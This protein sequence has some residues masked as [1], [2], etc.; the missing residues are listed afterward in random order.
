MFSFLKTANVSPWRRIKTIKIRG[1][2]SQ[3][4]VISLSNLPKDKIY[5]EGEDVSNIL[6]VKK[7]EKIIDDSESVGGETFPTHIITKTDEDNLRTHNDVLTELFNQKLYITLKMDGSSMSVIKDRDNFTV[8]SRRMKLDETTDMYNYV[9]KEGIREKLLS[10][11]ENIAIQGEF[12]GPKING[13]RLGLTSYHYYIFN[14]KRLDIDQY[15][16]YE[17]ILNLCTQLKLEMVPLVDKYFCNELDNIDTFQKIANTVKYTTSDNKIV[18]GEGIV[19]RP[20]V[21]IFS[22]K[23]TKLLSVKVI[24]Q[25]YND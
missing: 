19:I 8:C 18:P 10:L 14:I 9:I 24:N 21:P 25:E 22:E 11:D 12:C 7:Y 17:E 20:L 2:Y 3:G 13:N 4:L 6:N 23:L 15:L 16:G 5:V 1:V